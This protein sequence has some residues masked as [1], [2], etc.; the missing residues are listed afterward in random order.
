V[1]AFEVPKGAV[2]DA[3]YWD[4]LD[5]YHYVRIQPA[6]DHDLLL[7]GGEDHK[8][9]QL[10]ET[11]IAFATL[12]AYVAAELGS[13]FKP[14]HEWSGQII[15]TADELPFIGLNAGSL[16][17]RNE[18]VATGYSG[19]GL[20]FG[21]F[22]GNQIAERIIS[23]DRD[24]DQFDRLFDPGRLPGSSTAAAEYVSE[25]VDYPLFLLKDFFRGSRQ[26][27]PAKAARDVARIEGRIVEHDGRKIGVFR[28]DSGELHGVSLICPHLGCHVHWNASEKSWDCPCHGSRFAATGEVCN[29]PAQRGLRPVDL[30]QAAGRKAAATRRQPAENG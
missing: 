22:A 11:Q 29:G 26:G 2:P 8:T 20:T 25:N 15:E 21:S 4:T 1:A 10:V 6:G 30:R 12:R 13:S 17:H 14:V 5:P 18:Y 24:S 19:D 7:V 3:L 16:L 9:G 23:G 28:D 27:E